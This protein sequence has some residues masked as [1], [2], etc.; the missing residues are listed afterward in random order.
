MRTPRIYVDLPLAAGARVV[1]PA[2]QSQHLTLVLRLA[3]GD[4]VILF[5]GDGSDYTARLLDAHRTGTALACAAAG[6]QEPIPALRIHLG[7]GISK[8]ERMDFALQKAVDE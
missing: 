5:N 1:L 8:G 3:A 4:S 7:L 2:A 6:D